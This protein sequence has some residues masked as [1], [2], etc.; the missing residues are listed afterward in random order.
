ME[1]KILQDLVKAHLKIWGSRSGARRLENLYGPTDHTRAYRYLYQPLRGN[2]VEKG[3]DIVRG[4]QIDLAVWNSDFLWEGWQ[5]SA[6]QCRDAAEMLFNFRG[7]RLTAYH[8]RLEAILMLGW[9]NGVESWRSHD[10]GV[11]GPEV[12]FARSFALH[13]LRLRHLI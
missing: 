7:T 4:L 12:E 8:R 1:A 10:G 2:P 5:P 6:T 3:G 13:Q 11:T 9:D